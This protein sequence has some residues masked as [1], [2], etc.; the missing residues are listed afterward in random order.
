VLFNSFQFIIFYIL[1]VGVLFSLPQRFRWVWLL[2]AST[3]FYMCWRPSYVVFLIFLIVV[4][5]FCGIGMGKTD[6][7]NIKRLLLGTSLVSNLGLLFVFKYFNFFS[8][9][10]ARVF[11]QPFPLL[12]LILP[13]GISFHVFQSLAYT[14]DVYRGRQQVEHHFGIF[15]LFVMFFPQLVAGPIERPQNLLHQFHEYRPFT[16]EN[17]R[18]GMQ[19]ALWGMIKK[20][21]IADLV[22]KPVGIVYSHPLNYSGPVLL[23]ATFYF[24]VQIYCDF[25]GYTDIARGVAK[26]MGYDLMVNFRQPYFAHSIKE[27]WQRWHISL[28][29]WFRDYVYYP[30]GG[31]RA[32]HMVI[33]R[34]L[35]VVFVVSGLW[36][37]AAWTFVVWGALHGL[38]MV[39]GEVTRDFRLRLATSLGIRES[40]WYRLAQIFITLNLVMVG[41]VF[42][43]SN[44]VANAWYIVRHMY[45]PARVSFFD[46]T[47]GVGLEQF[48]TVLAFL[49]VALLIVVDYVLV[50]RPKLA[51]TWWQIRPARWAAYVAAAY[52]LV[53]FGIWEQLEFIYFQF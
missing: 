7:H 6:S 35:A 38:Y 37:G 53:F 39:V 22:A 8:L 34:N 16:Y 13:I 26:I 48:Q 45:I 50:Y 21:C 24:T 51:D 49:L 4:D 20:V 43:R 27:F 5:Y 15:A 3:Y 28:S 2:A 1:V 52:S 14:I 10:L 25:S 18:T 31:S 46:I 41:W 44:S 9:N 17:F 11:E 32:S 47:Y 19:L 40:R 36:H 33:L 12:H 42:F 29:T 30:L 23:L